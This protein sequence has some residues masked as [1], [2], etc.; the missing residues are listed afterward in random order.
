MVF[1]EKRV[2]AE[3]TWEK[4]RDPTAAEQLPEPQDSWGDPCHPILQVRKPSLREGEGYVGNLARSEWPTA[5]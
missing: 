4:G 2:K 1:V 5:A 3:V